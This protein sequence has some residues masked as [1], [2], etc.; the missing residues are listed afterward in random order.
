MTSEHIR[1]WRY[2]VA[3]SRQEE[4]V[5]HYATDGTWTQLFQ[6]GHGYLGTTLW[7][8]ADDE[9]T[10][11]TL[12]RWQSEQDFAAFDADFGNVYAELDKQLEG[13]A[14]EEALVAAMN[15]ND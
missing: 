11:Y 2:R 5:H 13:I 1:I 7:Q 15:R 10:W 4:F 12:D 6:R 14:S 8:D 3:P 9:G